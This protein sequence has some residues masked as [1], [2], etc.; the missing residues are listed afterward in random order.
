V[1]RIPE[2]FY[3]YKDKKT[4]ETRIHCT[5]RNQDVK[6]HYEVS[7][8]NLWRNIKM[9]IKQILY[10]FGM[11]SG[12]VRDINTL[13]WYSPYP[14][15]LHPCSK[16]DVHGME[17]CTIQVVKTLKLA[18][19]SVLL[20]TKFPAKYKNMI[21]RKRNPKLITELYLY[22]DKKTKETRIHLEIKTLRRIM[23]F[24]IIIYGWK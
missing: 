7:N 15:S 12:L 19:D 16:E 6:T 4:K 21:Y 23:R 24:P 17:Q 5:S 10:N 13:Q 1:L 9:Y 14:P 8:N 18:L 20:L 2:E 22:K 3:L 11:Y